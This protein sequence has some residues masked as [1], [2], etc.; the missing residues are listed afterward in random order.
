MTYIAPSAEF[1]DNKTFT[2][3]DVQIIP[4]YSDV[5][6]RKVCSTATPFTKK[7]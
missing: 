5:S 2:F 1:T 3:D 4:K 6:S 7:H